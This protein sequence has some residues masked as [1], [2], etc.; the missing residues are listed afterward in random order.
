MT[1]Q[2]SI[3]EQAQELAG[4]LGAEP[5][6]VQRNVLLSLVSQLCATRGRM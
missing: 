2:V 5:H 1:S 4:K 3:L 6:P